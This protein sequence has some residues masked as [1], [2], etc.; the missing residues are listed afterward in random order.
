M[1]HIA[2]YELGK[3]IHEERLEEANRFRLA[4]SARPETHRR[5]DWT[6]RE[7]HAQFKFQEETA[8]GCVPCPSLSV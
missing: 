6:K 4:R 5:P 8:P 7:R 2:L 3:I 1:H